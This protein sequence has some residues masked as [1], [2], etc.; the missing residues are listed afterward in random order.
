[1]EREVL[2]G[3]VTPPETRALLEE[4]VSPARFPQVAALV[5]NGIYFGDPP[6]GNA[7]PDAAGAV[8]AA[9]PAAMP[10]GNASA[11]AGATAP[12]GGVA[13]SG[14]AD[15]SAAADELLRFSIQVLVAGLAA[16]LSEMP[17]PS[18]ADA[19]P[20]ATPPTPQQTYEAAELALR[21]HIALRKRTQHRV[22]DLERQEAALYK[23]RDRAKEFAKAHAK[24]SRP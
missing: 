21:E 1:V 18:P 12:A 24:Q 11:P 3:I 22:R 16:T 9:S 8:S 19:A 15:P 4:A 5:R 17:P 14:G 6:A 20:P 2:A 23:A 10:S 13:A 7:V